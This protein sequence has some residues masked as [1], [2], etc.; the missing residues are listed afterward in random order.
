MCHLWRQAAR[1]VGERKQAAECA[2]E[3]GMTCPAAIIRRYET[4]E[5]VQKYL[6]CDAS[7]APVGA[8]GTADGSE[9]RQPRRWRLLGRG[10]AAGRVGLLTREGVVIEQGIP[11]A[12]VKGAMRHQIDHPKKW[13]Q[14]LSI[15]SVFMVTVESHLRL[16]SKGEQSSCSG[17][18]EMI[19]RRPFAGLGGADH[20]WL[21][22]KHHFSFASYYDPDQM[23]WGN[24]RVWNDDEIA[25]KTGFPAASP[26]RHGNHHLR[27][28]RRDHPQGFDGQRRP[29]RGR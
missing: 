28:R 24:L 12:H 20:G 10:L 18:Y 4:R 19:E 16:R 14:C 3:G 26:C 13:N 25:A 22:A 9:T 27:P 1:C 23:G 5:Q 15:L 17:A 21:K 29:H 6:A 8:G 2:E 11:D 7:G